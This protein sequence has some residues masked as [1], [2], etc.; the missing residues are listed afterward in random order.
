MINDY[1]DT[2]KGLTQELLKI[3]ERMIQKIKMNQRDLVDNFTSLIFE[4]SVNRGVY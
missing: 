2:C 1:L 3:D 4:K